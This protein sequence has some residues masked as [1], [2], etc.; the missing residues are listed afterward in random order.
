MTIPRPRSLPSRRYYGETL[1]REIDVTFPVVSSA[2]ATRKMARG[3][4]RVRFFL[5]HILRRPWALRLGSAKLAFVERQEAV[6]Y[7]IVFQRPR[8]DCGVGLLGC[9]CSRD[10]SRLSGRDWRMILITAPIDNFSLLDRYSQKRSICQ[11]QA[12]GHCRRSKT[13]TNPDFL[14]LTSRANEGFCG[15]PTT[16]ANE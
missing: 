16:V 6:R 13:Y 1:I 10:C 8:F 12:P 9:Q 3:C 2:R 14:L 15:Q 11:G 4:R 7:D 5:L